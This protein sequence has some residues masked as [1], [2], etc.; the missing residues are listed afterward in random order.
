MAHT[1]NYSMKNYNKIWADIK[2][3]T[4][5]SDFTFANIEAP[6]DDNLPLS[7]YPAFNMHKE[8][9]QAAIDAGFNVFSL[10]NNHTNDQ[11]LEGINAT[12]KYASEKEKSTKHSSR[13]VYFSGLKNG[14]K[15]EFSYHVIE[16]NGFRLI[17]VAITQLLN[18]PDNADHINFVPSKKAEKTAFL[19]WV[20]KIK[21]ENPC[22]FFILS[23]H[24]NEEEYIR[25]V[26]KKQR[27]W[28]TELMNSGVDILWANHAHLIK[29]QEI[30]KTE[31][32]KKFPT[33]LL[34]CANGNTISGQRTAPNLNLSFTERDDTGDGLLYKVTL[35]KTSDTKEA[36]IFDTRRYFITTYKN[37]AGEYILKK[38]DDDFIDYLKENRPSWVEYIQKRR[39]IC[40]A[41]ED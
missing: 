38:M 29:R 3:L 30:I 11:Y 33:K 21:A 15:A 22:D 40:E 32:N 37:T 1:V 19:E 9:V 17:F 12:M 35:R 41:I 31:K 6:V 5:D 8:Y 20:K 25:E 34:M 2:D 16:K 4:S 13:P 14:K 39:E 36:F 23:L 28:Y 7:S 27:N 24:T 26:T 18:R 10:A